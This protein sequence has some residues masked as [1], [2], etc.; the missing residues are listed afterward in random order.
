MHLKEFMRFQVMLCWTTGI[1]LPKVL[2]HFDQRHCTR[3]KWEI[4]FRMLYM[5]MHWCMLC[6]PS[7]FTHCTF[8]QNSTTT[9]MLTS[10]PFRPNT[11]F[12]IL[13]VSNELRSAQ[14]TPSCFV[15]LRIV[16]LFKQNKRN[17]WDKWKKK[18]KLEGF[19]ITKEYYQQNNSSV[20]FNVWLNKPRERVETQQAMSW[21][22][23]FN[24]N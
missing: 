1:L 20:Q 21:R 14:F 15:P 19:P 10:Q 13:A 17:E 5:Y 7:I 24:Q 2:L 4:I 16:T 8:T 3:F 11:L 9:I 18:L 22:C 6:S 12:M 23:V